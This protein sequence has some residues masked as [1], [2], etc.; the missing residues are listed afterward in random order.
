MTDPGATRWLDESQQRAWR[1]L[2]LGHTL[3]LDRLDDDLREAYDIS[4]AEYEILVRLSEREGRAMRMAQ[5]ADALAHSRS[6]VT[7]T[8]ARLE[9]SGYVERAASPEDG[10]GV[11]ARLTDKGM[12]LLRDAAHVHVTGVRK[13]IVDLAD[14][15]DFEAMG[16][17]F[18]AV[19]DHLIARHPEMELRASP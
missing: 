2:M 19:A 17:V 16:R 9:R 14:P 18:D 4:L 6:R 5:L 12:E 3:L 13:N 15:Q 7:H 1:A 11:V 10:R 8:I